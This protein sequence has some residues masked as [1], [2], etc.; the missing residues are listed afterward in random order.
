MHKKTTPFSMSNITLFPQI[1]SKLDRRKFSKWVNEKQSDKNNK[2][3]TTAQWLQLNKFS[4]NPK[5]LGRY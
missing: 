5:R 1:I 4:L 3:Y 2:G